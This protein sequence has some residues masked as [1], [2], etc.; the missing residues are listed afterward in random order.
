LTGQ[1]P[2]GENRSLSDI[3]SLFKKGEEVIISISVARCFLRHL[4]LPQNAL[5]RVGQILDLDIA[6][7]TPFKR[8]DVFSGWICYQT[9]TESSYMDIE[10]VLIQKTF[11]AAALDAVQRS[12]AKPIGFVAHDAA[13]VAKRMALSSDG[14]QF[15]RVKMRAW[16]RIAGVSLG[17]FLF[18][19]MVFATAI[20]SR[21]SNIL[22]DVG[23]QSEGLAKT[24]AE[25]RLKL[26]AIKV[27]STEISG[28][29][30][31]KSSVAGRLAIIE[32]LSR[33]LPDTAYLDAMV[34]DANRINIDGGAKSPEQLIAA[35]ESSAVFQN[36]S[37]SS[38]VFKNP[39]DTQSHFSIKFDLEPL[40]SGVPN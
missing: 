11:V 9:H 4:K 5:A 35:L 36:V 27:N 15:G 31:R 19:I 18:S 34:I 26:D 40:K 14:D 37:F 1:V 23:A 38:P 3:A 24:V 7:I 10:H 39:G 30:L 22:S 16:R 8:Q 12:G 32:E 29:Q 6:R 2:V 21:Q 25:V 17:A 33:I 13:G 20:V 28:L